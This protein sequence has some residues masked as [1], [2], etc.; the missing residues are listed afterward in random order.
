MLVSCESCHR[1]VKGNAGIC[2]FCAAILPDAAAVPQFVTGGTRAM[3]MFA[4]AALVAAC[5]SDG[6]SSSGSQVAMYGAPV[7]VDAGGDGASDAG[8]DAQTT[9]AAYGGPMPFDAGV[10]AADAQGPVAAYGAPGPGK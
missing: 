5:S 6:G 3:R 9:V 10:D 4:A 2:P 8:I 1:H 7:P